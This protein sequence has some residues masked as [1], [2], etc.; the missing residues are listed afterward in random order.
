M[1]MRCSTALHR[2]GG[3]WHHGEGPV[4]LLQATREGAERARRRRV[5]G[6]GGSGCAVLY[7]SALWVE[8]SHA[9]EC[10][11]GVGQLA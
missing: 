10:V 11:D 3:M 1:W 4:G 7:V 5:F 8:T 9:E 2:S 6:T